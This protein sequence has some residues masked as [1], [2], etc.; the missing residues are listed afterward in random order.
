MIIDYITI[1]IITIITKNN[2]FDFTFY[3]DSD[4]KNLKFFESWIEYISSGSDAV[5]TQSNYYRRMRYPDSYKCQTITITK[6][7]IT[8]G[9]RP[10]RA[11]V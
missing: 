1:T 6:F 8:H 10:I 3:I 9:H 5:P 11:F 4:Y 7:E 2:K